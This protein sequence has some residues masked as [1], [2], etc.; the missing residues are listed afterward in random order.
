M[1]SSVGLACCSGSWWGGSRGRGRCWWRGRTEG[2][3]GAIGEEAEKEE[4]AGGGWKPQGGT[5][6]MVE[7]AAAGGREM[8]LVL[9]WW[10]GSL[11]DLAS[12]LVPQLYG[13][14]MVS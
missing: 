1:W 6:E 8:K 9:V 12:L 13:E 4:G 5:E 14:L 7:V 11:V 3:G 2:E 10:R